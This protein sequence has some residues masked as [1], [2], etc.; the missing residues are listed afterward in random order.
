PCAPTGRRIWVCAIGKA[1]ETCWSC[2]PAQMIFPPPLRAP[3]RHMITHHCIEITNNKRSTA[4]SRCH[5]RRGS[6]CWC[7]CRSSRGCGRCRS[8]GRSS[9]SSRSCGGRCRRGNVAVNESG[10]LEYG[11]GEAVI[12]GSGNIVS[13][14]EGHQT[15]AAASL[16]AGNQDVAS[17]VNRSCQVAQEIL[18]DPVW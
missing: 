18:V 8:C 3:K 5:R 12:E 10:A 2:A 7:C 1:F 17:Y 9:S 16:L 4:C 11:A 14:I 6:R 15:G 13:A